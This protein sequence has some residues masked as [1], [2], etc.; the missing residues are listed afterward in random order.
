MKLRSL[1]FRYINENKTSFF[2]ALVVGRDVHIDGLHVKYPICSSKFHQNSNNSVILISI[3]ILNFY[4]LLGFE[5]VHACSRNNGRTDGI[6]DLMSTP[7][8]CERSN[9]KFLM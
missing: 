4:R 5:V 8:D 1:K 7:H 2:F 6:R 9:C 3:L